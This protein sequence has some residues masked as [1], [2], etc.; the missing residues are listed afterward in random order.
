MFSRVKFNDIFMS[1]YNKDQ[2]KLSYLDD[3]IGFNKD[4]Q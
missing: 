3:M 2:Y 4:F 1:R